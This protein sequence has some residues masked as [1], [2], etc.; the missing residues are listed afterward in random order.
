MKTTVFCSFFFSIRKLGIFMSHQSIE[1]R[2]FALG[3]VYE[4]LSQFLGPE[5]KRTIMLVKKLQEE[6]RK[7]RPNFAS[8]IGSIKEGPWLLGHCY[9]PRHTREWPLADQKLFAS[10]KQMCLER[11]GEWVGGLIQLMKDFNVNCET[12][13]RQLVEP[14]HP[15]PVLS[16]DYG[17]KTHQLLTLHIDFQNPDPSRFEGYAALFCYIDTDMEP[18]FRIHADQ[19]YVPFAPYLMAGK[20]SEMEVVTILRSW[21]TSGNKVKLQG[22]SHAW[23]DYL[24]LQLGD[25]V[26]VTLG[27]WQVP[28]E[29]VEDPV[30]PLRAL[31]LTL[32]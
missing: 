31:R 27:K 3:P 9:S 23:C 1:E 14:C 22:E 32:G 15:I 28:F 6:Q 10:Y 24:H 29:V 21:L 2:V 4:R 18:Y 26:L 25:Q 8:D 5:R 19:L 30:E 13:R 17:G 16:T 7:L 12:E 11:C 20:R